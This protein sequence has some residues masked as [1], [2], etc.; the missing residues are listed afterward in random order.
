MT[1]RQDAILASTAVVDGRG[2]LLET[3]FRLRRC[4]SRT[5]CPACAR[6]KRPFPMCYRLD[7]S[8]AFTAARGV[9]HHRH[10]TE[11]RRFTVPRRSVSPCPPAL[12]ANCRRGYRVAAVGGPLLAR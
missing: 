5:I 3:K 1:G 7:A 4:T 11:H 10:W 2:D 12:L 6:R 8:T 9:G